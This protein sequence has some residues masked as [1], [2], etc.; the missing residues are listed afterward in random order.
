MPVS[1]DQIECQILSHLYPDMIVTNDGLVPH[2]KRDSQ[3]RVIRAYGIVRGNMNARGTRVSA[4]C[5]TALRQHSHIGDDIGHI[6]PRSMGGSGTHLDNLFPQNSRINRGTAFC[7]AG[8][9]EYLAENEN[10]FIVIDIEF[11]Y[12]DDEN[13]RPSHYNGM[14]T[15]GTLGDQLEEPIEYKEINYTTKKRSQTRRRSKTPTKVTTTDALSY[16]AKAGTGLK[17]IKAVATSAPVTEAVAKGALNVVKSP[18]V[19]KT[20]SELALPVAVCI[21]VCRM[22]S[23]LSS[24]DGKKVARTAGKIGTEWGAMGTGAAIG[25]LAGPVGTAVGAGVGAIFGAIASSFI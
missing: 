4:R 6:V 14:V 20:A 16:A 7:D 13:R 24:G 3:N 10:N 15:R 25:S 23:A 1:D 11:F 8:N 12:E 17:A 5:R 22:G 21:D 18:G 2:V 9:A 19:L